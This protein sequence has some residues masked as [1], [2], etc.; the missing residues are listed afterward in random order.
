MGNRRLRRGRV[1]AVVVACAIL[2]TTP[3]LIGFFNV[4]N[5]WIVS[6][7]AIFAAIIA[8]INP[9]WQERYKRA[10][11]EWDEMSLK[12][13]EGCIVEKV[14]RIDDPVIL[15]V[16]PSIA[17]LSDGEEK[18]VPYVQRDIDL[19]LRRHLK[20]S[21]FV[22]LVGES[23]A[24]KSRT[25]FEAMRSTLP[26]HL[27]IAPRDRNALSAA[28]S[29][30]L[31][32]RKSVLW[33]DDLENYLGSDG[34]TMEKVLRL[35]KGTAHDR[36][37][38]ATIRHSEVR[39]LLVTNAPDDQLRATQREVRGVLNLAYQISVVRRFSGSELER[40]RAQAR[41]SRIRAALLHA[42]KYGIAEY[43][44]SGPELK[45]E[46]DAAWEVGENPRGA[47]LVA[48]AIDCRRVGFLSPLPRR[49]LEELHDMYLADRGGERLRPE[50][51][52]DAWA[53]ATR[54]GPATTA[55]LS[56]VGSEG[57][58]TVF[59]YLV[60]VTQNSE[61][62]ANWTVLE[63]VIKA[64]LRYASAS[65][66]L[67]LGDA[68]FTNTRL[69]AVAEQAF[70]QALAQ[71]EE[72]GDLRGQALAAHNLGDIA[73][74]YQHYGKAA[75][76]YGRALE[77]FKAVHDKHGELEALLGL[78]NAALGRCEYEE[79][80]RCY[81]ASWEIADEIEQ[82]SGKAR[83]ASGLRWIV[84]ESEEWRQAAEVCREV[85]RLCEEIGDHFIQNRLYWVIEE[86]LWMR[87]LRND[88]L[89]D[90][91]RHLRNASTYRDQVDHIARLMNILHNRENRQRSA[92][93]A[94]QRIADLLRD[95][96][97]EVGQADALVALGGLSLF[98]D[99]TERSIVCF[100]QA[101]HLYKNALTRNS[102]S[103]HPMG[104]TKIARIWDEYNEVWRLYA[105]SNDGLENVCLL[106]RAQGKVLDELKTAVRRLADAQ[107][108]LRKANRRM[109]VLHCEY[110]LKSISYLLDKIIAEFENE[111]LD[112]MREL[113]EKIR[114]EESVSHGQRLRIRRI[115]GRL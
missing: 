98:D 84:E 37:I 11:I 72:L 110:G 13:Q 100:E 73:G 109:E 31:R 30:A 36:V 46:Y 68:A 39:R 27:L 6:G 7:A 87:H 33:L 51:L 75:V 25:A 114:E 104:R 111:G 29:R 14:H 89:C 86:L 54:P 32:A 28:I 34:L 19:E 20:T 5:P 59:D 35:T 93:K 21:R 74:E 53:W 52:E 16:H 69:L 62:E 49:L 15:G 95:I 47:S 42:D 66:S 112:S 22:V 85:W 113:R 99:G 40:A 97:D 55:L 23:A 56:P 80:S 65:D 106:S 26:R 101:W 77:L 9:I 91:L 60:D 17:S 78:G 76:H 58:V 94:Y 107:G 41:D 45:R 92:A 38:L 44:A 70:S 4:A 3:T 8:A 96:G 18:S 10:A 61:A 67:S 88:D 57:S 108:D 102:S 12:V 79:A 103:R 64:A 50:P 82:A 43:L 1:V 115:F 83:A 71:Y 90:Q 48:A 81:R 2:A 24:G 63:A 105:A